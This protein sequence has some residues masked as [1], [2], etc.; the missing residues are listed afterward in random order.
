VTY[1]ICKGWNEGK[2]VLGVHI[3]GLLDRER[4]A[5]SKGASPFQASQLPVQVGVFQIM[6]RCMI[7][8]A[9]TAQKSTA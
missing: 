5:S 9:G 1:E 2:G 7:R 3:H 8:Q 6:Y 4:R